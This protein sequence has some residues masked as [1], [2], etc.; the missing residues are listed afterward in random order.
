MKV[1]KTDIPDVLIFE[2]T[3]FG[4]ERGF[5]MESFN[6]Q[7]FEKAVGRKVEFVQDNHSKSSKGVLRGLHYQLPPFAQAKLVR[8]VVGE[9]YDVAVDIRRDS[10]TFGKWVGV[11]LSAENKRQLW[12]PEGFAHG[13]MVLSDEAEFLYKTTNY[14]APNSDRGLAWNDPDIGINWPLSDKPILSD[15]DSKQPLLLR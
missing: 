4:D 8:C 15:K 12:I 11:N 3:V 5:F 6:Q 9:V 14:Y 7:I 13:F 10:V 1:I 2:P